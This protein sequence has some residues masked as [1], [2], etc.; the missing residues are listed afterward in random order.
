MAREDMVNLGLGD[1]GTDNPRRPA[2]P[3]STSSTTGP[4]TTSKPVN[5][6]TERI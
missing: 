2:P 3:G 6:Q 5:P 1:V 4:S